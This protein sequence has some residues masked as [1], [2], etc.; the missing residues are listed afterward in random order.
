MNIKGSSILRSK[1]SDIKFDVEKVTPATPN[2]RHSTK[3][4]KIILSHRVAT[5]VH[6]ASGV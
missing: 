2:R 3:E 5:L 1:E 6:N 4:G